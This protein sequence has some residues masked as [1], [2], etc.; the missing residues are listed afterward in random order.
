VDFKDTSEYF[1]NADS[2]WDWMKSY[3]W[4]ATK[5]APE[6]MLPQVLIFLLKDTIRDSGSYAYELDEDRFGSFIDCSREE[7]FAY[8]VDHCKPDFVGD[9]SIQIT[10]KVAVEYCQDQLRTTDVN[11]VDSSGSETGE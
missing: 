4:E 10:M 11:N 2:D 7:F 6:Y 8:V 5:E 9:P 3:L 1:L